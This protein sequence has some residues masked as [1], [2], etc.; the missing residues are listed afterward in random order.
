MLAVVAPSKN[1]YGSINQFS[2]KL[3]TIEQRIIDTNAEKQ[4]SQA[5]TDV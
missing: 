1:V 2:S 4:L 3:C 5:A